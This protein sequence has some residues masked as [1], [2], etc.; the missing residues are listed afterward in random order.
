MTHDALSQQH[1]QH[2]IVIQE[3]RILVALSLQVLSQC[4]ILDLLTQIVLNHHVQLH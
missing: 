1:L 4:V 3:A 2:Q